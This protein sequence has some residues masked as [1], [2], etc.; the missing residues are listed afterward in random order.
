MQWT[1]LHSTVSSAHGKLAGLVV[2]MTSSQFDFHC[3]PQSAPHGAFR[4]RVIDKNQFCI[5]KLAGTLA[6]WQVNCFPAQDKIWAF[7]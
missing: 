3:Y 5:G 4:L 6:G 2:I 7:L 1:L